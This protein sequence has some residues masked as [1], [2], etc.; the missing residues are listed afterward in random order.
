MT[1]G[2]QGDLFISRRNDL[3]VSAFVFSLLSLVWIVMAVS[4]VHVIPQCER[5]DTS[6][7]Y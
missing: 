4:F 5:F 3:C 1:P 2:Y 7:D 6:P